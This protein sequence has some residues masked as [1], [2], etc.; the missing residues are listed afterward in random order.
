MHIK[1]ITLAVA[2]AIATPVAVL[3]D[4]KIGGFAQV[5]IAREE[6]VSTTGTISTESRLTTTED[7]SRGRFWITADEDLAYGMKGLAHFEFRVDTTGVC[8]SEAGGSTCGVTGGTTLTDDTGANVREKWVGLKAPW[9]TVKAGSVRSPYKYAGGVLLDTFVTTNLEARGTGG[10][11][12]GVFGHNNFVDNAVSYN[13][14]SMAGVTINVTYSFDD[15]PEGAFA[16]GAATSTTGGGNASTADDGDYMA[17]VEWAQKFSDSMAVMVA[18][19]HANNQDNNPALTGTVKINDF[20]AD[21]IAAKLD[22][23]KYFTVKAQ[24][25]SLEDDAN[26]IDDDVWF[27]GFDTKLGAWLLALQVGK[28]EQ[29]GTGTNFDTDYLALGGIYNFSKSFIVFTGWRSTDADLT[30]ATG[31]PNSTEFDVYTVGARKSF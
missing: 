4:V 17:S 25:E 7:N 5:E 9:G 24:V 6:S 29:G 23:L 15:V 26:V 22:F 14:P 11:S 8:E 19:A 2:A 21:K 10:M 12:G 3:A 18:I 31:T 1:L 27:V 13:S 28:T 20:T 30:S 16:A